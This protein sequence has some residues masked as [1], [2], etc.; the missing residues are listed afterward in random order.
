M[1]TATDSVDLELIRAT[2]RS[3]NA[4]EASPAR[5]RVWDEER[6]VPP[7]I[8]VALAGLGVPALPVPESFGGAGSGVRISALVVEELARASPVLSARYILVAMASRL[9]E[10][11]GSDEQ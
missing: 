10:R 7:E 5:V 9:L 2:I 8:W 4:A 11:V 1:V 6:R 3:F